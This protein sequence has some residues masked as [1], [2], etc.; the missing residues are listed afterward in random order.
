MSS[1]FVEEDI[2]TVSSSGINSNFLS[3][4]DFPPLSSKIIPKKVKHNSCPK[5]RITNKSQKGYYRISI[6]SL[7]TD[8]YS[9]QFCIKCFAPLNLNETDSNYCYKCEYDDYPKDD[10][11]CPFNCDACDRLYLFI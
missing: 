8:K 4:K 1:S 2:K 5:R 9:S 3:N 11:F 7:L 10:C 6:W